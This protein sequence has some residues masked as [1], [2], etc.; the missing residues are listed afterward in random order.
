MNSSV[1][2]SL[3]T[4][5]FN[6]FRRIILTVPESV[7]IV[8]A[9]DRRIIPE[10]SFDSQIGE[11]EILISPIDTGFFR[12][13]KLLVEEGNYPIRLFCAFP[14]AKTIILKGKT[15]PFEKIIGYDI[16]GTNQ[17]IFDIYKNLS[18]ETDFLE[19]TV[20]MT[21]DSGIN[22]GVLKPENIENIDKINREVGSNQK[23]T[24]RGL[25]KKAF[26]I[27]VFVILFGIL[28]FSILIFMPELSVIIQKL[29]YILR[30]AENGAES[31]DKSDM[32]MDVMNSAKKQKAIRQLM[33]E[34][35]VSY[36]E[37]DILVSISKRRLNVKI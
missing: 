15:I 32:S 35:G 7:D 28:V 24:G 2:A 18:P 34:K 21:S 20:L 3:K 10:L 9:G 22:I 30:K 1:G 26:L 4:E 29:L 5:E 25:F 27:S 12:G 33:Q 31:A 16:I 37:A 6:S 8:E 14:D 17:F 23:T 11:F 19:K 13:K 36:D